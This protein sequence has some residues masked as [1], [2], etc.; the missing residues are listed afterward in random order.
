[1]AIIKTPNN[2]YNGESATVRFINGMGETN[3]ENL[4]AWFKGH[5]YEVIHEAEPEVQVEPDAEAE[6]K[7]EAEVKPVKRSR[8]K[9]E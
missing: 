9:A 2:Q 3:D 6:D 1:M 7:T 4:I 8:K 5:G